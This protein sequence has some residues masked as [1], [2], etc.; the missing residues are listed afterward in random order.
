MK[1]ALLKLIAEDPDVRAAL[2]AAQQ[3]DEPPREGPAWLKH[4]HEPGNHPE[5][6]ESPTTPTP[7]P[8]HPIAP[9]P[10]P[11]HPMAD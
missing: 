2:R 10:T 7:T 1:A 4:P 11:A 8:G 3:T 9:G 6:V 5:D